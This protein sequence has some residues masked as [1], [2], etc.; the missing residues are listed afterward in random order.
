M[1][2]ML[3]DMSILIFYQSDRRACSMEA[4]HG[5]LDFT[6]REHRRVMDA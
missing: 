4:R 1:L 5:I 6:L 2:D 3:L